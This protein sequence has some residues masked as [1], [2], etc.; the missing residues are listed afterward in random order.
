[1]TLRFLRYNIAAKNSPSAPRATA[2]TPSP[3]PILLP[4]LNPPPLEEALET[5]EFV[6]LGLAELVK[7][8]MAIDF[9]APTGFKVVPMPP[10]T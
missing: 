10:L 1:L 6:G 4:K 5:A 9:V 7:P 8:A 2:G 3:I